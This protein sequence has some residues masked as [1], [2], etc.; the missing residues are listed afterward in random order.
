MCIGICKW[1]PVDE[2]RWLEFGNATKNGRD[3]VK[4]CNLILKSRSSKGIHEE[5]INSSVP[6]ILIQ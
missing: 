4:D 5:L 3:W 6:G 2:I 1:Q